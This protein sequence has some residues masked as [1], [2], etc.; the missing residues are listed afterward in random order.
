LGNF[1]YDSTLAKL[2]TQRSQDMANND[3]FSHT[4]PDGCDLA[5]RFKKSDYATLSWGENLAEY[6][7][8]ASLSESDLAT[9]FSD[10]WIES[11]AHRK[12]LLSKDFTNEGIGVAVK[13]KRIVVT[14]I[15]A[16]S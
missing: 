3:Y 10:K 9:L 2:A 14:V 7:D 12:N 5:C 6:S 4:S 8:Y 1:S 11:S 16:K 13:G 15:F